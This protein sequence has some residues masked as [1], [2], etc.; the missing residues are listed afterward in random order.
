MRT[1]RL[2][3]KLLLI[4]S[5]FVFSILM[6]ST[7]RAQESAST[8]IGVPLPANGL[9]PTQQNRV[10]MAVER[11]LA[12]IAGRQRRDGSFPTDEAGQP[13]VTA[14]CVLAFLS[15]GHLPG[16]GPYGDQIKSAIDYVISCQQ[17][18][19]L[20]S[21][22]R[23][24]SQWQ[25][26]NPAHTGL[27]NHT[28]S[29]LLLC[30]VYGMTS[31]QQTERIPPVIE[32][33]L[34]FSRTLQLV[35]KTNPLDEGAWRYLAPYYGVD[36]DICITS[37]H[38]MF[39]RS[40]KNAGFDVPSRWVDEAMEFVN[41]CYNPQYRVFYYTLH[42][43]DHVYSRGTT[44]AGILSLSLAGLHDTEMAQNAANW[45]LAHPFDRYAATPYGWDRFFYAAFYCSQA[46]YQLGGRYWRQFYPPLA[47]TLLSNQS[48]DGSWDA[49]VE[50]DRLFGNLYTTAMG[51]LALTPEN[52]L[53]PIFQ[54]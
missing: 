7:G 4:F 18:S 31:D 32:K 12:F 2:T 25:D 52:Q 1:E 6:P 43:T 11:A 47:G 45:V 5:L 26:Y 19:G 40:A 29:G 10:D 21:R 44:G 48:R 37:W 13:G 9:N 14:L 17:D 15:C 39:W 41:R 24:P 54:R 16:Q 35:K 8:G 51:V 49:S 23:P 30:E 33:A 3:R 34:G 27:Y 50:R 42:G 22:L 46:M 36:G 28:I 20:I 38:L 53:L